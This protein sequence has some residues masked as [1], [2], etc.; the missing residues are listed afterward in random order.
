VADEPADVVLLGE[1]NSV[2]TLCTIQTL[3]KHYA[4]TVQTIKCTLYK[5]CT[6]AGF[7]P[8]V[9]GE[10][11]ATDGPPLRRSSRPRAQSTRV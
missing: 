10:E 1:K 8:T 7:L 3:Y 4:N 6:I 11:D 2:H 9:P 5:H